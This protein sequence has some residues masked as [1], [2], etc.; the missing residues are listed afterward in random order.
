MKELAEEAIGT[1][2]RSDDKQSR[3]AAVVAVKEEVLAR[4]AETLG[5]DAYVAKLP[6]LGA[7]F[8]G[9]VKEEVRRLVT[10]ERTR[11]DG[12]DSMKSGPSPVKWGFCPHPRLRAFTRGQ[13]QV[14]TVCTLGVKSDEQLLDD[15]RE[16][17]SKRYIHHY[18]FPPFCVGEVRPMRSPG[19]REI[20]HGALAERA[21]LPMIPSEEE[22]PYTI[23]L[24]S[25]PGV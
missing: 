10:E 16:E 20:G 22:F 7:I 5:E 17:D 9:L 3:E 25:S 13:T 12:R 4:F 21:L 23:R 14:L 1:A 18:N 6:M 2:I 15:L 24:V 8:D 19:R 11:V